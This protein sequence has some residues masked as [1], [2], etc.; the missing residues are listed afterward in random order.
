MCVIVGVRLC[1]GGVS[2]SVCCAVLCYTFVFVVHSSNLCV[3]MYSPGIEIPLT[4]V[5][6][7]CSTLMTLVKQITGEADTDA[8]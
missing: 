8:L 3:S 1:V 5:N 6:D 7:L 2:L 4:C